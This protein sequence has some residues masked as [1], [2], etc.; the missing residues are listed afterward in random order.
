LASYW[1][2][3]Q[4]AEALA[5]YVP[6]IRA[7]DAAQVQAMARMYWNPADQSIVVVGDASAIAEQLAPYGTFTIEDAIRADGAKQQ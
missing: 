7:V 5:Q 6:R 3:G 2:G 1:V 4:P